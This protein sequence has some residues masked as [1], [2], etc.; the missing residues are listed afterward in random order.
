MSAQRS[1]RTLGDVGRRGQMPGIGTAEHHGIVG[2]QSVRDL[3][4]QQFG[5][6]Q[7]AQ[8]PARSCRSL[9]RKPIERFHCAIFIG[10]PG[11]EYR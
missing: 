10:W 2:T 6:V 11:S 8:C 1:E 5:D 7:H 3:G 4:R 9:A